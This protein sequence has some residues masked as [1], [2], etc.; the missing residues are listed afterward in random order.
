[1]AAP[2]TGRIQ[3]TNVTIKNEQ[4]KGMEGFDDMYIICTE[5]L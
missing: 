3:I 5:L 4:L 2:N 1:M